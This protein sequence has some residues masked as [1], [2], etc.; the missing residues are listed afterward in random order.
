MEEESFDAEESDTRAFREA[1]TRALRLLGRRE[2]SR[3]ELWHK[4]SRRVT[5]ERILSEV[6][7]RLESEGWL[8][9]ARFADIY[10]RQRMEMG[11]GPLR[12][13]AE[14]E[15]RGVPE[16]PQALA[17]VTEEHWCALAVSQRYRRFGVTPEL[18]WKEKGR[19][20]R[21]LAQR[22]FSMGQIDAA[23]A[24]AGDEPT[25]SGV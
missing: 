22:G 10:V 23:L 4:L 5:E 25:E 3:L 24:R 2:H 19:Q 7:D 9:D 11:Y 20:G 8:N 21:F 6:L 16:E 14:L 13:R 1:E 12:I 17:E 15:Q 18:S